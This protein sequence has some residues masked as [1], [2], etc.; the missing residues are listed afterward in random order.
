MIKPAISAVGVLLAAVLAPAH[1]QYAPA[2]LGVLVCNIEAADGLK[3][4]DSEST[5]DAR[6]V[7]CRFQP[8]RGGPEE[9]YAGVLSTVGTFPSTGTVMMSVRGEFGGKSE[10]GRLGQKY[11]AEGSAKEGQQPPL[12]GATR[13]DVVLRSLAETEA[14]PS[15]ALGSPQRSLIIG[16]ELRLLS[17][18]G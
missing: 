3:L 9:G 2:E 17:V 11:A 13:S 10:A 5:G 18:P 12:V 6:A 7:N 15:M 16:V 14:L 8:A 1:A 4:Q